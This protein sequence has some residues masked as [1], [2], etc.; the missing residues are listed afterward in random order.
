MK[1]DGEGRVYAGASAY[2]DGC[3]ASLRPDGS[4]VVWSVKGAGG[5]DMDMDA[6]SDLYCLSTVALGSRPRP[7]SIERGA[8]LAGDLLLACR[9]D[10]SGGYALVAVDLADGSDAWR[11]PLPAAR[12]RSSE[13]KMGTMAVDR[14]G[15]IFVAVEDGRVICFG[16]K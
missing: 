1:A 9:G 5:R 6:D 7:G 4:A 3:T 8:V 13:Y 15:R 11:A 16:P 10:A 2:G 14:A 12:L